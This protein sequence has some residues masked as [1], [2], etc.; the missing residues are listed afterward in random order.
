VVFKELDAPYTAGRPASGGPQLKFKFCATASFIVGAIN[1]KRSASL[2]LFDAD[3]VV[4]AGNVTIP[5]NHDHPVP[6]SV[7]EV[8]YLYAF[9][10]SGAVFQPVYLGRRDGEIAPKECTVEQLKYKPDV[11]EP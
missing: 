10:E 9:K 6:G 5:P 1:Q 2:M 3:R 11:A 7:V 8:R 4:P